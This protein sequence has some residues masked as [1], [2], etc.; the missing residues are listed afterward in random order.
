MLLH[1]CELP[2]DDG[3]SW[4]LAAAPDACTVHGWSHTA[5]SLTIIAE[6]G[7][8]RSIAALLRPAGARLVALATVAVNELAS[9]AAAA[10]C[11]TPG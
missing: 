1:A 4:L 9:L 3:S 6:P 5:S 8:A 7:P 11:T 10:V 2:Q